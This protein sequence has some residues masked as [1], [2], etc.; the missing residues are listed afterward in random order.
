VTV[1]FPNDHRLNVI[2]DGLARWGPCAIP[3][4]ARWDAAP[5]LPNPCS[6]KLSWLAIPEIC[7]PGEGMVWLDLLGLLI[8]TNQ[9]P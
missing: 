9:T 8:S 3:S 4:T 1:K 7:P 5:R 2:T 6:S